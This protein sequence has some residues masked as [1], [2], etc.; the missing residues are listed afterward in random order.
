M[1]LTLF[2]SLGKT[3]E[4]FKPKNE[5]EVT[6]YC[7]GPTVYDYAHVGNLRTFLFEDVLIRFLEF[8]GY[9]VKFVMNIT[10]VDDKTIKAAKNNN[11][12]LK[13]YTNRFTDEFFKDLQ[14]LNVKEAVKYPRATDYIKDIESHIIKLQVEE[15]CYERNGS[16]YYAINKFSRYGNLSGLEVNNEKNKTRLNED[17]YTKDNAQDFALWKAWDKDDG[18]VYWEGELGKGRPGWHIECSVMSTK[19]LG[20]E[21]DIHAGGVDLIFPHHENEIAQTEAVTNKRFVRYW[22]H[23]EHL[24]VEGKKMSKSEGNFFTLR[25]LLDKGYDA[26]NIRFLLISSHYRSQLNFTFDGINQAKESI[27]RIQETYSKILECKPEIGTNTEISI[28]TKE[29]KKAF[30]EALDDDLDMPKALASI[31]KFI[32]NINKYLETKQVSEENKSEII[33]YFETIDK[34]LGILSN[35]TIEFDDGIKEL[36]EQRDKAREK[37]D[38]K[39]SDEIREELRNKGFI[40]EDTEEGTRIKRN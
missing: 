5:D 14:S 17:E 33:D 6:V 21:I 4:Q 2:N 3:K 10:D 22:I 39:R 8:K 24:I 25:D 16:Y 12:T 31:F 32:R 23:S 9:K 13:E 35:K 37:K 15:Y 27:N 28:A 19:I 40:V 7:C 26:K 20:E 34:I 38:W 36:I 29:S 1:G 30:E 11:T 18:D